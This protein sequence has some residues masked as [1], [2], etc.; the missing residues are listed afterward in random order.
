[1]RLLIAADA[2]HGDHLAFDREDRLYVQELSGP[3]ARAP[4]APAAAKE[5]ERVDGED[6]AGALAEP[7]DQLVDSLVRRASLEP[8]L[9]RKAEHRD[10]RGGRL[11]ID[12]ADLLAELG[13]GCRRALVRP[14]ERRRDVQRV[15]AV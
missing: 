11:G 7:N 6:E 14:G 2:L 12:R 1:H 10:R 4:D 15:G 3:R 8:P 13:S 9:D 5:L